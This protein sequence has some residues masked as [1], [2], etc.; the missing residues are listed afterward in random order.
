MFEG[1]HWARNMLQDVEMHH[2][3]QAGAVTAATIGVAEAKQSRH[4][5]GFDR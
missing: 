3:V 1:S 2:Q 4:E 5:A